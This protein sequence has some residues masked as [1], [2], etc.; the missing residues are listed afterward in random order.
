MIWTTIKQRLF[1]AAPKLTFSD[2]QIEVLSK[3]ISDRILSDEA[4]VRALSLKLATTPTIFGGGWDRVKLGKEVQLVNTLM[5]VVSGQIS[6]GDY[7]FFGHNVCLLTGT[8]DPTKQLEARKNYPTS[9]RN[10]SI[11]KG[12]WIASNATIIGPCEIG[13]NAVVA[14]GSVVVG[15]SVSANSVYAGVPAR[16][17]K[18]IRCD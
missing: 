4:F 18:K 5:N 17:V 11:G 7:S 15:G 3:S 12:V 13:D 9:S 1:R 6:I 14:A 2:A 16:E 8:H 10:I